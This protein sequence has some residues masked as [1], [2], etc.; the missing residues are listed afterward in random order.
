MRLPGESRP[1]LFQACGI[2]GSD[3][4]KNLA[5]S[6]AFRSGPNQ[7]EERA[8]SKHVLPIVAMSSDRL[9]LDR[10]GR[11]QS[12]F[13]FHRLCLDRLPVTVDAKSRL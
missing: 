2:Y 12:P 6:A 7:A 4:F 1:A 3:V 10:V 11:H 5:R 13:P 9:L 8:G